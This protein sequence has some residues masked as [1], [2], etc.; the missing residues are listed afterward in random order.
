MTCSLTLTH[1]LV[2]LAIA[3]ADLNSIWE[4]FDG[5]QVLDRISIEGLDDIEAKG[6]GEHGCQSEE[7]IV[8]VFL[9]FF[10]VWLLT[11]ATDAWPW[12]HWW[13][14]LEVEEEDVDIAL[15][16]KN[17]RAEHPDTFCSILSFGFLGLSDALWCL[18]GNFELLK[19]IIK[20][21]TEN[22]IGPK[23][24]L[25]PSPSR[26]LRQQLRRKDLPIP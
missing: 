2:C 16:V 3:G 14:A 15:L 23:K 26:R 20:L 6:R 19:K 18:F 7:L 21:V 11:L 12:P 13:E 10:H 8:R 17:G 5:I 22:H 4:L 24:L 9:C 25:T 1:E